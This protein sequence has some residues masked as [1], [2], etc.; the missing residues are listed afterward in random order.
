MMRAPL[1]ALLMLFAMAPVAR[2]ETA[3]PDS[4]LERFFG[5]LSDSTDAYFG[6]AVA[7]VDTAGLDSARTAGLALPP[8]H[9]PH[10]RMRFDYAPAFRFNRVDGPVYGGSVEFSK[11]RVCRLS[12]QL[13]YAAGP[14]V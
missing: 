8:V 5:G 1:A 6:R 10:H 9:E 3:A 12:P 7:P 14:N 2:A 13:E 4:T 11:R